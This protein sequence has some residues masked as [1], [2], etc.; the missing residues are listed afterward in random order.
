[1]KETDWHS[2]GCRAS[3]SREMEVLPAPDGAESTNKIP[4]AGGW[5]PRTGG[6]GLGARDWFID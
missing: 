6:W 3:N 2:P 4:G 5:E 1:V